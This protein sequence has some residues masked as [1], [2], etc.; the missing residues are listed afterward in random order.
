MVS[1]GFFPESTAVSLYRLVIHLALALCLFA[2]IL[3][4]ALTMADPVPTSVLGAYRLRRLCQLATGMVA[5]TI[6]AVTS[7]RA[8]TAIDAIF[9]ADAKK[10]VTGVGAPW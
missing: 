5:I 2:A 3:W 4:T 6:V 1:S 9:T 8:N 7:T 10:A